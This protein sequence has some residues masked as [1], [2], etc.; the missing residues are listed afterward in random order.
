[1]SLPTQ[2]VK[3]K[4]S[5][6]FVLEGRKLPSLHTVNSP[7]P[8]G[9][10]PACCSAGHAWEYCGSVSGSVQEGC[11]HPSVLRCVRCL[12]S[13]RSRCGATRDRKCEPCAERHR[14]DISRVIRTG[15]LDR[16]EGVF[17][18]TLTAPGQALLPWDRSVCTHVAGLPCSGPLGCRVERIAAAIWNESAP[19]RW[20]DF[21]TDLR[22]LL[23]GVDV[24]SAGS[25]ETQE[26]GMLHRHSLVSAAG[27]SHKRMA[28]CV[29]SLARKHGFGTRSDV[30]SITAEEGRAI[31]RAS[32]Y[33]ASYV[34]KGGERASLMDWRTSEIREDGRGYRAWSQTRRWGP[35][36]ASVRAERRA[37]VVGQLSASRASGSPS[38]PVVGTAAG[39]AAALDLEQE[40]YATAGL[41]IREMGAVWE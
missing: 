29:R 41:L 12:L 28:V 40:I 15:A 20:N 35:T 26:R 22:R 18:L 7:S 13:I 4:C 9:G 31:S 24:Q 27:V 34:T 2:A 36:L 14:L 33:I 6:P 16:P 17:F 19:R 30:Q 10:L 1:M 37:W 23:P 8:G 11:E 3:E 32:G 39:G 38:T 25:W 5:V 21:T